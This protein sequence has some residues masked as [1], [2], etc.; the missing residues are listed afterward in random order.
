MSWIECLL[1]LVGGF[2]CCAV[3]STFAA[4]AIHIFLRDDDN[5]SIW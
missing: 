4:L 1:M 3:I 5:E 2:I